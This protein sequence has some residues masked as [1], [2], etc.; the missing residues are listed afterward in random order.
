AGDPAAMSVGKLAM[1]QI[2]HRTARVRRDIVGMATLLDEPGEAEVANF[3]TLD[4]YFTSI[5]GGTDQI[6]R[7][8]ISERVLGLRKEADP[9]KDVPFDEVR[10]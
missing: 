10:R 9:S 6:Q 5:G 4:A 7:N 1:S 2:L 3:F 8:I